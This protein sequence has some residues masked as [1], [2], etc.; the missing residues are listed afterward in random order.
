[1]WKSED[2]EGPLIVLWGQLFPDR[3]DEQTYRF[4]VAQIDEEALDLLSGV[5]RCR[6]T[7][8]AQ[9]AKRA[10]SEGEDLV[11]IPPLPP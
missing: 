9:G 8:L 5:D 3:D 11:L 4:V 1:M 10:K 6:L 7:H 2:V